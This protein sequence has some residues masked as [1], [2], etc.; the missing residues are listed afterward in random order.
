[1]ALP[2]RQQ[3]MYWSAAA[4]ALILVLMV[5]GNV[6]LPFVVGMAIA[7]FLDPVADRLEVWGLSRAMATLLI[8][9]VVVAVVVLAALVIVP[10]LI[11]QASDLIA[12]APTLF[13]QLQVSIYRQ[14]PLKLWF[15]SAM[16]RRGFPYL[17]NLSDWPIPEAAHQYQFL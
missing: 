2:V 9:L 17:N 14:K 12:T 6:I 13:Q 15:D 16:A 3:I 7:Y 4:V 10:L 1:M 5:L 8:S 11:Q